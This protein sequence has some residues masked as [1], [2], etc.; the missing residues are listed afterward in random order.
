[1]QH[2]VLVAGT[3]H[4]RGASPPKTSAMEEDAQGSLDQEH[5]SDHALPEATAP[6][7]E[8]SPELLHHVMRLLCPPQLNLR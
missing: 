8:L 5:L 6:W 4:P 1:M 2:I 7:E 3:R